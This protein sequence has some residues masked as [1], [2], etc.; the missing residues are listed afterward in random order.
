M[1]IGDFNVNR[2]KNL[3]LKRFLENSTFK[4][5]NTPPTFLM[6]NNADSTPDLILFTNNLKKNIKKVE[7]HPDIGSDHLAIE[8]TIDLQQ[9]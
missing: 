2:A 7:T 3:Q 5:A 8:I 9:Q 1:I 6:E 4:R